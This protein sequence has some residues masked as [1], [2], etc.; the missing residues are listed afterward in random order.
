M[1]KVFIVLGVIGLF[2]ISGI[3]FV[4]LMLGKI[5]YKPE[6]NDNY[7]IGEWYRITPEGAVSSDGTAWHGLI[8]VGTNNKVMVYMYGGGVSTDEYMAA[9][10]EGKSSE[11]FYN[12]TLTNDGLESMGIGSSDA[13]NPFKDWTILVLPYS[14]GDWHTGTGE[15]DY[16]DLNG[17]QKT[18][19][20]H[21]YTNANLFLNEA[22][23]YIGTPDDV[24]ITGFSGG[25]FGAAIISDELLTNYFPNVKSTSVFVESA[26]LL[27]DNWHDIAENVWHCPDSITSKLTT[28][29]ITLDCLK[30]L[31]ENHPSTKILYG[32][33][34][35]DGALTMYQ[36]YYTNGTLKATNEMGDVF[37]QEL[38]EF[39]DELLKL[40]NSA[41]LIWDNI[42]YEDSNTNLTGHVLEFM[43]FFYETDLDGTTMA[44]WL[45]NAINGEMENHG[46]ELLNK[47]YE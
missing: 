34:T 39:V 38:K 21:G 22:M 43:P 19:Y 24:L 1:K 7:K 3:T 14:T 10:P 27:N 12:P 45:N 40:P 29:N 9:R 44:D 28:N 17:N 30:K 36:N 8:R 15:F 6:I 16:T 32:G 18:L 33:S 4:F 41:V 5:M 37:Q 47:K 42:S 46:L 2:V 26:L 31:S 13:K 35:R 11:G 23:K 25:G 20:H